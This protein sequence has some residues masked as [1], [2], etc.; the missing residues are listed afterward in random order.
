MQALGAPCRVQPTGVAAFRPAA[1]QLRLEVGNTYSTDRPPSRPPG[2]GGSAAAPPPPRPNTGYTPRTGDGGGGR[3]GGGSYSPGGRGGGGSYTPGGRGGGGRGY[4]PGGRGG[5]SS[6]T[7]TPGGRGGA[8]SGTYTPGGRGGASTGTHTPGGRG[9]ASTGTYTP[10]GRGGAS[11]G[12]YT[13]GGRG[14]GGYRSGGSDDERGGGGRG[15]GNFQ[16]GGR[17]RGVPREPLVPMNENIRAA[18]VRVL[19]EDKTPLGV[20]VTSRAL[21]EAR[22][23]GMDLIMIVP[24]AAPP[25]V[26]IMEF[27]KY[28][29]EL[30]KA[31]KEA[32]RKQR[33]AV[34]ETKEVK[35]RPATDVHDYQVKVKAAQKFLGKGHRVKLTLQF[36]GR[37]MEFQQIGREMFQRF[38]EDC[39]GSD[40]SIEQPPQMQGRQMTMLLSRKEEKL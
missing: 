6:G 35:L 26:R 31:A 32:K 2:S 40:V 3:G 24:D 39:G 36:R 25:V 23:L 27:S 29:Y 18:E 28:N 20:M 15:S 12:T 34:V 16:R 19:A 11:S 8:S 17:G 22:S 10:G 30:E 4:T 37:E 5:A 21:A 13:P 33:E 1:R 9:G 7:Y 14:G 38:V